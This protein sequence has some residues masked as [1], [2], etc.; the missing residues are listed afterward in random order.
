MVAFSNA[1]EG[2]CQL[3]DLLASLPGTTNPSH[4]E[5]I[6]PVIFI[7][8]M[9]CC[10]MPFVKYWPSIPNEKSPVVSLQLQP[11]IPVITI[12]LPIVFIKDERSPPFNS[13]ANEFVEIV[14]EEGP[15][16]VI[17]SPILFAA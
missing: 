13:L 7:S 10:I 9:G 11:L 1:R 14:G 3:A 5:I 8:L 4:N 2:I 17:A 16:T 15:S 6:F 12:P